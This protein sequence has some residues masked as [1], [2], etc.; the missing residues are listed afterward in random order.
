[1]ESHDIDQLDLQLADL[2]VIGDVN[3]TGTLT[4]TEINNFNQKDWIEQVDSPIALIETES[5][6][7]QIP[8]SSLKRGFKNYS[9]NHKTTMNQYSPT[10]FKSIHCEINRE[11]NGS[12]KDLSLLIQTAW[13]TRSVFGYRPPTD[14]VLCNLEQYFP[15][16]LDSKQLDLSDLI[17]TTSNHLEGIQNTNS[18][19]KER[20]VEIGEIVGKGAFGTVYHGIIPDTK[21]H[22]AVKVLPIDNESLKDSN[23][24]NFSQKKSHP[25]DA[26]NQMKSRKLMLSLKREISILSELDHENIV[27]FIGAD[28]I[29]D[30]ICILLEY[31]S[32]GTV[33]SGLKLY[34]QFDER[35]TQSITSQVLDGLEYLHKRNIVHRDI[36]GANGTLWFFILVL[37]TTE[38]IA[39]ISDF[40]LSRKHQRRA[41]HRMTRNS[42]VGTIAWASPESARGHEFTAKVDIWSCGCL[43]LEMLTGKLPWS[44]VG[45]ANLFH[46]GNGHAPPIPP[47]LSDSAASFLELVFSL[48]PNTRPTAYEARQHPFANIDRNTINF[49][50]WVQQAEIRYQTALSAGMSSIKENSILSSKWDSQDDSKLISPEDN[51]LYK[52]DQILLPQKVTQESPVHFNMP[53]FETSTDRDSANIE[54]DS[55]I[56][57]RNPENQILWSK[58]TQDSSVQFTMSPT[59]QQYLSPI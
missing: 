59:H 31:V 49:Q 45:G 10:K 8:I 36:K 53:S 14:Q 22:V 37:I 38:G 15:G 26:K 1:M 51:S 55:S 40:G 23:Y 29:D 20:K 2:N 13:K 32:G 56:E 35:V 47:S 41:Y 18:K 19:F 5:Q 25:I 52:P 4:K 39:K 30:G 12:E 54:N 33:A 9:Y 34:G 57:S 24:G 3:L 6:H 48:D 28:Y 50:E 7:E 17:H 21:T 46:I 16:Q 11:K 42:E 43:V 27:K 58:E 44:Q